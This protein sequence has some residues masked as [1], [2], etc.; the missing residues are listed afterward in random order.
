MSS[1]LDHLD[2]NYSDGDE[3]DHINRLFP[4]CKP[5]ASSLQPFASNSTNESSLSSES[6]TSLSDCNLTNTNDTV[7]HKNI[8]TVNN[9]LFCEGN[10]LSVAGNHPSESAVIRNGHVSQSDIDN[11]VSLRCLSNG[12]HKVS[13]SENSNK[14]VGR[15]VYPPSSS[16]SAAK[17]K[18]KSERSSRSRRNHHH[19]HHHQHHS[20]SSSNV[21]FVPK[22]PAL[23]SSTS[24]H[25]PVNPSVVVNNKRNN[26]SSTSHGRIMECDTLDDHF[27]NGIGSGGSSGSNGSA[28]S[29]SSSLSSTGEKTNALSVSSSGLGSSGGNVGLRDSRIE[30]AGG[31]EIFSQNRIKAGRRVRGSTSMDSMI[32]PQNMESSGPHHGLTPSSSQSQLQGK[33]RRKVT[34]NAPNPLI[35]P[36]SPVNASS[37]WEPHLASSV[38]SKRNFPFSSSSSSSSRGGDRERERIY[39][40]SGSNP[41]NRN[42][43][44]SHGGNSYFRSSRTSQYYPHHHDYSL[45]N[46][47]TK[48][49]SMEG[50]LPQVHSS[51]TSA[52][53]PSGLVMKETVFASEITS[54]EKPVEVGKE[55]AAAKQQQQPPFIYETPIDG[56]GE[57]VF[58]DIEDHWRDDGVK[59]GDKEATFVSMGSVDKSQLNFLETLMRDNEEQQQQQQHKPQQPTSQLHLQLQQKQQ[60]SHHSSNTKGMSNVSI[61]HGSSPSN[62]SGYDSDECASSSVLANN[63]LKT[64]PNNGNK[65]LI[66]SIPIAE[67]EGSPKR[68]GLRLPTQAKPNHLELV[69]PNSPTIAHLN[70]STTLSP[71]LQSPSSSSFQAGARLPGFPLRIDTSSATGPLPNTCS[72]SVGIPGKALVNESSCESSHATGTGMGILMESNDHNSDLDG[73]LNSKLDGGAFTTTGNFSGVANIMTTSNPPVSPTC[74]V[75][76]ATLMMAGTVGSSMVTKTG[77]STDIASDDS[78]ASQQ[79]SNLTTANSLDD[80]ETEVS[81]SHR[82]D[83]TDSHDD[84]LLYEFSE[85]RKVLEEFFKPVTGLVGGGVGERLS[86]FDELDYTLKRQAGNSYVGQRLASESSNERNVEE[87]P[88]KPPRRGVQLNISSGGGASPKLISFQEVSLP[89]SHNSHSQSS[90]SPS[91]SMAAPTTAAMLL[92]SSRDVNDNDIDVETAS[93]NTETDLGDTEV[94][95]QVGHSRNF[96]LSPETTDCDSNELESEISLDFEASIHSSSRIGATMPVLEDGLSSG[97]VSDNE[98]HDEDEVVVDR[99]RNAIISRK[100]NN[101]KNLSAAASGIPPQQVTSGGV[102]TEPNPTLLLMK[103]QISEIEKEI[104]LRSQRVVSHSESNGSSNVGPSSTNGPGPSPLRIPDSSNPGAVILPASSTS[105]DKQQID[106]NSSE[107]NFPLKD[108]IRPESNIFDCNDPELEAL[109]PMRPTPPPSPAPSSIPHHLQQ[110]LHHLNSGQSSSQG[111][112]ALPGRMVNFTSRSPNEAINNMCSNPN[113]SSHIPTGSSSN[114]TH[115]DTSNGSGP[116]SS[117]SASATFMVTAGTST[118]LNSSLGLLHD[119]TNNMILSEDSAST[120]GA[121]IQSIQDAVQLAKN[122]PS[123]RSTTFDA[124]STGPTSGTTNIS[125]ATACSSSSQQPPQHSSSSEERLVPLVRDTSPV[126]VPRHPASTSGNHHP[127]RSVNA[128]VRDPLLRKQRYEETPDDDADT[129]QETDRLLGQNRTEDDYGFYDEKVTEP[130]F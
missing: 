42:S 126:W 124:S 88:K 71:R 10:R 40:S 39:A 107:D 80:A 15:A 13:S 86:N 3:D 81:A 6:R 65:R 99:K 54:I 113:S 49:P 97:N 67:Y 117:S 32:V 115:P 106:M 31:R 26:S 35:S 94:G 105:L 34:N 44:G 50:M 29:Q 59:S 24:G 58:D 57:I 19:H 116:T 43:G 37:I 120:G 69:D 18:G 66:G 93:T 98:D 83:V 8:N 84:Y 2:N 119:S 89:L 61:T 38:S 48:S 91:S 123:Q 17:S 109:D 20:G 52:K 60:H 101:N 25:N 45:T 78:V 70:V 108:I 36:S 114:N 90:I 28:F 96:T 122:L 30:I 55:A 11:N 12:P 85:T 121:D 92:D 64:S 33:G 127:H 47:T 5:R 110:P 104:K 62:P 75:N 111:G 76:S 73:Q 23:H 27:D 56:G 7:N 51:T 9:N 63:N 46:D 14:V 82:L 53:S 95:L 102:S 21:E 130:F 103:K 4:K 79:G 112:I 72:S 118:A 16:V 125:M 22:G 74:S 1:L 100:I 77:T 87:S 68:Y 128:G 129:D 41:L